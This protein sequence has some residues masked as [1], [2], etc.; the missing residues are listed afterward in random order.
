MFWTI[1]GVVSPW[2]FIL[3]VLKP[4]PV[5]KEEGEEVI[6]WNRP[7][8][9]SRSKMVFSHRTEYLWAV[10]REAHW[11]FADRSIKVIVW[12]DEG[13]IR[14]VCQASESLI[15]FPSKT[16]YRQRLTFR[17]P[18][19][20][21]P[22]KFGFI[23]WPVFKAMKEGFGLFLDMEN[24]LRPSYWCPFLLTLELCIEL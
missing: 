19:S 7:V 20:N 1:D 24:A 10:G 8:S 18:L 2:M 16:F 3:E 22:G 4:S 21:F 17:F 9:I 15:V 14:V 12:T 5:G 11:D 23:L 13:P 6:G